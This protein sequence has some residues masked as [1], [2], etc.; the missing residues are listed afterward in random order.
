MNLRQEMMNRLVEGGYVG[1]EASPA[2]FDPI[3]GEPIVF[4]LKIQTRISPIVFQ[5][6]KPHIDFIGN[7]IDWWVK[8]SVAD[9]SAIIER[10][11]GI[12][13]VGLGP[14]G[15]FKW[16]D[17]KS[18]TRFGHGAF[19]EISQKWAASNPRR[20][21][22]CDRNGNPTRIPAMISRARV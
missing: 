8:T 17:C 20:V 13:C 9:C 12:V 1:S 21:S 16:V 11:G 2:E 5:E 18:G 4:G 19:R 14:S 15:G 22:K 3:S 7:G 6:M 10:E